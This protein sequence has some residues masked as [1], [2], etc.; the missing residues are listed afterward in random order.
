MTKYPDSFDEV[1]RASLAAAEQR[2]NGEDAPSRV[3]AA[4]TVALREGDAAL[5]E[6][7]RT[8][9]NEGVR[10]SLVSVVANAE[11]APLLGSVLVLDA[12]SL[13]R[14]T[15]A[16]VLCHMANEVAP[17]VPLLRLVLQADKAVVVRVA[18]V[19]EL[20]EASPALRELLLLA[21][22]DEA[23]EV[24]VAAVQRALLLGVEVEACERAVA[25]R[26]QLSERV[27]RGLVLRDGVVSSVAAARTPR[28]R[29]ELLQSAAELRLS[30]RGLDWWQLLELDG[31]LVQVAR[32][33]FFASLMP[34]DLE[35][36][37]HLFTS[38]DFHQSPTLLFLTERLLAVTPP[39]TIDACAAQLAD[40][41]RGLEALPEDEATGFDDELVIDESPGLTER[42]RLVRLLDEALKRSVD[43]QR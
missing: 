26:P 34:P 40:L 35:L 15:A 43:P 30:M 1:F 10:A 39:S 19:E 2:L 14:E 41:M 27:A 33:G 20:P 28:F 3:W 22:A 6:R 42:E 12:S 24:Q 37:L 9:P 18:I 11:R 23:L 31:A 36:F 38:L 8:E 7:L 5:V 17:V 16:R 13:V 21:F 4:W 29:R 32:A 25:S